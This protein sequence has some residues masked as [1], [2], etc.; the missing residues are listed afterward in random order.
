MLKDT[1]GIEEVDDNY[2]EDVSEEMGG[3]L[4]GSLTILGHIGDVFIRRFASPTGPIF[5]LQYSALNNSG[6]FSKLNQNKE[7]S[8]QT[9]EQVLF[10]LSS[11]PV[12]SA[13]LETLDKDLQQVISDGMT[14][15][16]HFYLEFNSKR[17]ATPA[18]LN[19]MQLNYDN[20]L[21]VNDDAKLQV[22]TPSYAKQMVNKECYKEIL[23]ENI[24]MLAVELAFI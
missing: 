10:Y 5:S 1:T 11:I 16:N 24:R 18:V 15:I 13:S 19:L 7:V 4:H 17:D 14:F 23:P 20:F 12:Q 6:L 3:R 22:L 8:E 21:D 2:S 9:Q